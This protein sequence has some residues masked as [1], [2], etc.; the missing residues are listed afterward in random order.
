MSTGAEQFIDRAFRKLFQRAADAGDRAR[1]ESSRGASPDQAFEDGRLLAFYEVIREL[2]F[3]AGQLG[4]HEQGLGAPEWH[5]DDV[6]VLERLDPETQDR[7]ETVLQFAPRSDLEAEDK[8]H[9]EIPGIRDALGDRFVGMWLQWARDQREWHV[10][11]VNP[12][13]EDVSAVAAGAQRAG[14]VAFIRGARYSEREVESFRQ[15]I[16]AVADRRR[17]A[18]NHVENLRAFGPDAR[19]NGVTVTMAKPDASDLAALL[20]A[21]PKDALEIVINEGQAV[22]AAG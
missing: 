18:S 19:V 17:S 3:L 7:I 6:S 5:P 20:A 21:V 11:V 2:W 1:R 4:L 14:F 12:T 15:A 16:E 8:L 13:P 9:H 22:A 10:A